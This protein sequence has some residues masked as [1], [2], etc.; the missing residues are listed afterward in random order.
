[1]QKTNTNVSPIFDDFDETK[2]YHR[3]LFNAGKAV[4]AREL[5]Q[6]QTILQNQVERIG[7][8][9]FTE[10]SMVVPGGIKAIES[11]DY[12]KITLNTGSAYTDFAGVSDLFAKSTTSGVVF[13][14][15][16][17]FD[18]DG[19]DPVTLFID[20]LT[21][22]SNQEKTFTIGETIQIYTHA[23]NG[24]EQALALATPT[25]LGEGAWIKV[26]AGI[27]FVRGMFIRTDDQDYVVSKYTTN[28]TKKVGFRV[29]EQIVTATD[30]PSLYSNANGFPNQN[31]A[32]ASRLKVTLVL[33]GLDIDAVDPDFI[34]IARFD[35]G[36]L[37][38]QIDY[39]SYSII[40]QAIAQRTYETSGDYIVSDFGM[41]I[42]EH[43][44]TGTN[45]GVYDAAS[46]GDAT[47]LVA[48]MKPGVGYVKG[49]RVENIGIQ[50]VPFDKARDTAFLN[51]AAYTADYGQYILLTNVKSLPD[52]DIK[53][54]ILLL[55]AT[56]AQIGTAR[57]RAMRS[58]GS[59]YRLYVFDLNFNTGKG[60]SDAT[61]VKYTDSSSL[62]TADIVLPA[63]MYNTSTSNL[64][65]KLP[66]PA[67]KSLFQTG[68]GGDTSYTVLRTFNLTTDSNGNVSASANANEFFGPVDNISYMIGLTGVANVGT[69]FNP[70]TSITLS[71]TIAGTTMTVSLG[72]GNA[73]KAIKVI[74][75]ILKNQTTQK[76]KTLLTATDEVISFPG[77]NQ[78]A[79]S[80]ADIYKIISVTDATTGADLTSQFSC[81]NGQRDNWYQNGK[82]I[83][84]DGQLV[85]QSVKVTYQYF[86]HSAGDYFSID[87]YVGLTRDGIPTYNN[88][89]LGDFIDFRPL[90]DSSGN[91][92]SSTV[93]GEIIKPGDT[94]RADITYY[95]PRA[96]LI[97]VNSK[98]EFKNVR[99]I[100]SL[101]ATVPD[102]PA[103]AMKLYEL[104]L[105]AY[106]STTADVSI[107][108]VDNRRYTMRDI[109]KL[110]N[111]IA[112]VEYYTTLSALE[113][114]ANKV[115]VLDPTTG[116]NR[117]KNGF[118]VDGFTDFSLA[119]VNAT[120]WSASLDLNVGQL[121]PAFAENGV[122]MAMS[123]LSA[124]SK[125]TTVY[126]PAYTE[127][128]AV[129][130]P[131]AT[132]TININ[133]YAVYGWIGSINLTPDRDYWTDVYYNQPI[134]INNTIDYTGGQPQGTFW[135]SWIK[136]TRDMLG[137]HK[138]W[139]SSQYVQYQ[140]QYQ[141]TVY[142]QDFSSQT[143]NLVS[144][145][146]IPFMR[147][148]PIT[149][150]GTGFRPFTRLYPFFD[151]VNITVDCRPTAGNFGDALYTDANGTLNAIFQV[152]CRAD[153]RF[154]VGTSVL[155]LTDDP[156]NT[157]DPNVMTTY[158]S[159]TFSSG[160]IAE[161]RQV[162]VTNTKVL[163]ASTVAV[164]TGG[165]QYIDPIAQTFI[166]PS[167]GGSYATKINIY[168]ATKS[169]TVPVTLQLRT[170]NSGLPT[171]TVLAQVTLLP[172]QV[173]T[174]ANGTVPTSFVFNDPVYLLEGSEYAIVLTADTQSYNVYIA[175]QGQNVI[176]SAMAL[177]K[178]AYTGVFLT[179]SNSSTWNPDQTADL[180]FDIYRASF[181]TST[182][183][184]VVFD[185][186]AQ[187]NV[188]LAFNA[189]TT[190]SGSN[191]LVV[192]SKSHGLLAGDKVTLYGFVTGN[193]INASQ[194]NGIQFTVLASDVDTFTIQAPTAANAT[195]SVGGSAMT[196]SVNSPFNVFSGNVDSF[197]PD[198]STLSWE[199]QYTSQTT[200]VKSGWIKFNPGDNNTLPSEAVVRGAGDF[201]YR[202]TMTTTVDNLA[203]SIEA[204]GINGILISLRVDATKK[205]FN[206]VTTNILFNNPTTHSRFYIGAKLPGSSVM[207]V[208]IKQI[209]S[210]D[211]DVAATVWTQLT[212][213]TPVTN[214]ENFVE[215]EYDYDSNLVG[216]KVKVELLGSNVNPPLLSDIRTISFA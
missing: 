109:G 36:S 198:G 127:V 169:T 167:K 212:P 122:D 37:S 62:F 181:S 119:D 102:T 46:G 73:N 184:V 110:E 67:I 103:D 82:L 175:R 113:S 188:P 206:Y 172:S 196:A 48:A 21:P 92:T 33:T 170:A 112:N 7:K 190:T 90:K 128:A 148:I 22:G 55:D 126:M 182:P 168:F 56:N 45:G 75:P 197:V 38:S 136:T 187:M 69:L 132:T 34:E 27:Y 39:T 96:D 135:G 53:K 118:A 85:I 51:N 163:T 84:V 147:S 156:S 176:G 42:K 216:Y 66:V 193:N 15:S 57:V 11:Q 71:G 143:D 19:T 106:T 70:L 17:T 116:N 154:A 189:V 209:T 93:Y 4:Q 64:L 24:A 171:S 159:T 205:I 129:S 215:Y 60:V 5:T 44:K 134:I 204:S 101:K 9:L 2:N 50:N 87:S 78:Q 142:T 58:D 68:V 152:P 18:V 28:Q 160:G 43:L 91:F 54:Q 12:A 104:Y 161:T 114:K 213:T 192:T 194:I 131:Y 121:N 77:T 117:F 130:Q 191:N 201:Q 86:A 162:T 47:K 139:A 203:P 1:M 98:G 13:Q 150:K 76:T 35:G 180:K 151:N 99:G 26:Q 61:K 32:G 52:I 74:A 178:Q 214:S 88:S 164:Q 59:Y 83:R 63:T 145:S 14:V 207:N 23:S 10:G 29:T 94:I 25:E 107:K 211:Q 144:T 41:D 141:T 133:P 179:S 80:K 140:Y 97:V 186:V 153:R 177:S 123:S 100:P 81:D 95:L 111:R 124:A 40:E 3:I 138:A 30:D 157:N 202:A 20:L 65:F 195:G 146:I 105:N 49:Y 200:R 108:S 155:V 166:M 158:G 183:G 120:D 165:V 185:N 210:A 199:Y 115:E 174:S 79:M 208:Y 8:H 31:A 16:K 72:A 6:A 137:G 173:N 149:I 89:N 125:R